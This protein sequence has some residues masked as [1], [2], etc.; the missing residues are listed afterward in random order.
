M[1]V[2]KRADISGPVPADGSGSADAASPGANANRAATIRD[3]AT[4][5]GVSVATVSRVITGNYP[6]AA[7]TKNR[8]MRA[9]RELDY[10]VNAHARALAGSR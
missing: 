2:P 9:V 6:V 3:V 10:V 5:A 8:V 4:R 7:P 1:A